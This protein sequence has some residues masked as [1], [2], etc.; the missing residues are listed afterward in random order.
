ED[1]KELADKWLTLNGMQQVLAGGVPDIQEVMT[2]SSLWSHENRVGIE[3]NYTSRVVNEGML[4]ATGH[5]RLNKNVNVA[6][7]VKGLPDGWEPVTPSGL[8]GEGRMTWIEPY[9]GVLP[10]PVAQVT[11]ARDGYLRYIVVLS[12]PA[13]LPVWPTQGDV[14]PGLPGHIVLGCIGRPQRLG[15]WDSLDR[16]PSPLKPLIPAGSVWFMEAEANLVEQ[17]K[18]LHGAHIGQRTEWGFGQIFIGTWKEENQS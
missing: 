16:K 14:L 8:G 3:R 7:S 13:D 17:V 11:P 5:I 6:L 9:S 18:S 2:S 4:Y 15:G 10:L 1:L 12:T